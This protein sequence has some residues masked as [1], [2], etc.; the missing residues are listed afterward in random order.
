M[1][2]L[3]DFVFVVIRRDGTTETAIFWA[4]TA[5]EATKYARA[6]AQKAGHRRVELQDEQDAA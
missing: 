5:H 3:A 6:W 4:S 2:R 1:K